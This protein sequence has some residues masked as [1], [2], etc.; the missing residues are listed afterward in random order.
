[1]TIK[2]IHAVKKP[3]YVIILLLGLR[4]TS[5]TLS[6]PV[7]IQ[8]IINGVIYIVGV[9]IAVLVIYRVADLL[10]KWYLK[11]LAK[12]TDKAVEKRFSAPH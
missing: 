4:L 2:I 5:D 9:F 6:L 8:E 10:L 7:R 11:K 3:I 12:K 1:M